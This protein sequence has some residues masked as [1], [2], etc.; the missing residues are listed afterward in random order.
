MFDG[1]ARVMLRVRPQGP[2]LNTPG[3]PELQQ[4]SLAGEMN[5]IGSRGPRRIGW[6][7]V[8]RTSEL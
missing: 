3:R 5:E 7:F 6:R 4:E 2:R 8:M 1:G